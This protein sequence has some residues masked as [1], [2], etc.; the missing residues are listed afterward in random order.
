MSL[1]VLFTYI[2]NIFYIATFY[3]FF[4]VVPITVNFSYASPPVGLISS[5]PAGYNKFSGQCT[6]TIRTS[7]I[8]TCEAGFSLGTYDG[9]DT[10]INNEVQAAT[11]LCPLGFTAKYFDDDGVLIPNGPLICENNLDSTTVPV[12]PYY[13]P[14]DDPGAAS[15]PIEMTCKGTDIEVAMCEAEGSSAVTKRTPDQ[16]WSMSQQ[17]CSRTLYSAVYTSCAA[18]FERKKTECTRIDTLESTKS[19]PVGYYQDGSQCYSGTPASCDSG[20][21]YNELTGFCVNSSKELACPIN[22]IMNERSNTCE[23]DRTSS[24]PNDSFENTFT[25]S[26][27]FG[28]LLAKNILIPDV[29]GTGEISVTP[30]TMNPNQVIE[31]PEYFQ[32]VKSLGVDSANTAHFSAS[33]TFQDEDAQTELLKKTINSHQSYLD[34]PDSS[35]QNTSASAFGSVMGTLNNTPPRTIGRDDSIFQTGNQALLDAQAGEGAFFG[36]CSADK[37]EVTRLDPDK[38]IKTES[39]CFKPKKS[40][41]SG[42]IVDRNLLTPGFN[43]ISEVGVGFAEDCPG[44]ENCVIVELGNDDMAALTQGPTSCGVI[45]NKVDFIVADGF[46]I[47]QAEILDGKYTDH[48]S[49]KVGEETLFDGVHGTFPN[50]F[51][52][53]TLA[54]ET[55]TINTIPSI[56]VSEPM[57]DALTDDG[58]LKFEFKMAVGGTGGANVKLKL[59]FFNDKKINLTTWKAV[60]SNATWEVKESRAETLSSNGPSSFLST[61]PYL[62]MELRTTVEVSQSVNEND[63]GLVFGYPDLHVDESNVDNSFYLLSWRKNNSTSSAQLVLAEVFGSL[64]NS[65]PADHNSNLTP[66]SYRVIASSNISAWE[67]DRTHLIEMK[68]KDGAINVIIDGASVLSATGNLNK[69]RVG[70]YS[71]N[72]PSVSFGDVTVTTDEKISTHWSEELIESPAGCIAKASD[73]SNFCSSGPFVCDREIQWNDIDLGDWKTEDSNG[74][75]NTDIEPDSVIQRTN[76]RDTA[77]LSERVYDFNSFR[78]EIKVNDAN[79]VWSTE[80]PLWRDNDYIG[81]IFGYDDES[82]NNLDPAVDDDEYYIFKWHTGGMP[83]PY[84]Q[85]IKV[86]NDGKIG[87]AAGSSQVLAGNSSVRWVTGTSHKFRIDITPTRISI[88]IDGV[89]RIEATGHFGKGRVGFFN[90]S[91]SGVQYKQ[92]QDLYPEGMGADAA[93]GLIFNPITSEAGRY[94]VCMT[95][96][97]KDY[98]C[99]P[100]EGRKLNFE[101]T[102]IGYAD[103][104]DLT[105][106][107]TALDQDSTCSVT[108]QTCI[109]GWYDELSDICYAWDV[110][111]TCEDSSNAMVTSIVENNS[112][113]ADVKCISGDCAVKGEEE[114][115]DFINA[116]TQ[117][118]AINEMANNQVCS[119]PDDFSTCEVFGGESNWCG[120]DQLKIN[121]CCEPAETD[122]VSAFKAV[123]L[124]SMV[125][126]YTASAE[127]A[128]AG[129][130]VQEALV[131]AGE[132]VGGIYDQA[133]GLIESG[134]DAASQPI[135]DAASS[136]WEAT[137]SLFTNAADV[138]SGA[139]TQNLIAE[140]GEVLGEFFDV[141]NPS[142]LIGDYAEMLANYLYDLLPDIMKDAL[143]AAA[144]AVG[145]SLGPEAVGSE[146]LGQLGGA[147]IEAVSFIGMVYAVYQL[148]KL[149]YTLLTA[150]TEPEL[151]MKNLLSE[152]KCFKTKHKPCKK[153]F[154]VC[155]S[156]AKNYYC[157]YPSMLSRIIMDSAISQLGYSKETYRTS[158][159]CRGI[160]MDELSKIDFSLVDY[161]EWTDLMQKA[162]LVPINATEESITKDH[163]SNTYGRMSTSERMAARGADNIYMKNRE[164]IEQGNII[165]TVSCE[166]RPRPK[167]CEVLTNFE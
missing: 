105:D 160:T 108:S 96:H 57:R 84:L 25:D 70:L 3:V 79:A 12:K 18:G 15:Q 51:P 90:S 64:A 7:L 60:D 30:Q 16:T 21:T 82:G 127:G 85:I 152:G 19:C 68:V 135:I 167:S 69:G 129:T 5:C 38:V 54:C 66:N 80:R 164:E 143:V 65:V 74:D 67:F 163:M 75:W 126:G 81:F 45:T 73:T 166:T 116:L 10:C 141:I 111:Y 140:T 117:Y 9:L 95:G 72:Q 48:L 44:E 162:N 124:T 35:A 13:C 122:E 115:D 53:E 27:S 158:M 148:V 89:P 34:S 8:Q 31:N 50:G 98:V 93:D 28:R 114:N 77:F 2:T 132:Y 155:T 23:I 97:K 119:D 139:P 26:A 1:V 36:D 131:N 40:N 110:D 46:N 104:I 32:G 56:D 151:P 113:F 156:R 121:D 52:E 133:T 55:N 125:T 59:R 161:T 47:S 99:D 107:C 17:I 43:M 165:N 106:N 61:K 109:D 58:K 154:G 33:G 146:V 118:S 145:G 103:L 87:G 120:W 78:G 62:N 100:L 49:L 128:F 149:A 71:N 91:Q 142:E 144:E 137:S 86:S 4:G 76:G 94:P 138:T 22:Q 150:C 130:A 63:I 24:D 41:F 102:N 136:A 20:Y 134:W 42:C 83:T 11:Q 88:E 157:C 39:T 101:G 37:V 123:Y 92:V 29:R 147:L 159:A 112:C 6:K 153:V 14:L